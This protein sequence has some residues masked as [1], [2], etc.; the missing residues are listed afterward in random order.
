MLMQKKWH[1]ENVT[2]KGGAESRKR[3]DSQK[4]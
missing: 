1:Q 4:S 3:N 2:E